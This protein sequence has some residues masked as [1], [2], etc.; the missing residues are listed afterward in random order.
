MND[1]LG[2][3]EA[4]KILQQEQDDS[5]GDELRRVLPVP[6]IANWTYC[7]GC[8]VRRDHIYDPE[9]KAWR[10]EFCGIVHEALTRFRKVVTEIAEKHLE[11]NPEEG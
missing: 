9:M 1:D 11:E 10:C 2:H 4:E 6:E 8:Y 7:L 5:Y 3:E